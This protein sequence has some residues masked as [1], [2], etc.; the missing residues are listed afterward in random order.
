MFKKILSLLLVVMLLAGFATAEEAATETGHT[1]VAIL[2][3]NDIHCGIAEGV[4]LAGLAAYKKAYEAAGYDV[5]LADVGDAIQGSTLGTLSK[6][7]Y[8]VEPMNEVGY[9][10]CTVGNHEFDYGMER[11]MEIRETA[12]WD[13]VCCNFTDLEGNTVLPPYVMRELGGWKVAFIGV[14]TPETFYKTTPTFFQDADGNYIYAFHGGNGGQDLYDIVQKYVDQA[15]G[16][17][18]E[19]VV[20]LCHLGDEYLGEG[21]AWL[22]ADLVANTNGIDVALDGHAHH[23]FAQR[24]VLNKDGKE[25]M[26]ASTGTQLANVGVLTITEGED[27]VV[28]ETSLHNES[29][30]QDADMAAKVAEMYAKCDDVLTK[31]IA[32]TDVDLVIYDPVAVDENNN[33]I[34]I[35]RTQETN[36]GDLCA[37]ACRV[38]GNADIAIIN[39]GAIRD[40]LPVGDI[41]YDSIIRVH[42]FNK[43]LTVV[44]ATGAQI[45]DMLEMSVCKLPLSNGGFMQVSGLTFTVDMSVESTV[46][47]A[48]N[49]DFV[50]V[51]GDR[52]VK[53]V[54]VGG[55]PIDPEKTYTVASHSYVLLDGGDGM[56]IFK[57]NNV[58]L[59]SSETDYE[60]LARYITENLGGV[61]GEAYADPYGDGRITIING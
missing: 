24:P 18:A 11:L 9:G 28:F 25:I 38:L 22:C 44:E 45:L 7:E 12:N 35:I 27:G 46:E 23:A 36:L 61:I 54:M 16:E 60:I 31:V 17:G 47:L 34:R 1:P 40:S 26:T 48:E 55:E 5:L 50:C 51:H 32:H 10:V 59:E 19:I 52:R 6:G 42:P 14:D 56:N 30:F 4:G 49:S 53:D 29:I 3:T 43:V 57:K 58:V 8:I 13:Y 21:K 33:P 39:G 20:A 37:D 41:T 15:R 2:F